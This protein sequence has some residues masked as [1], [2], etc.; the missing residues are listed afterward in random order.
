MREKGFISENTKMFLPPWISKKNGNRFVMH[1]ELLFPT[2]YQIFLNSIYRCY[3]GIGRKYW[4]T[5]PTRISLGQ[6]CAYKDIVM[7]EVL[8]ALGTK[9]LCLSSETSLWRIKT[10]DCFEEYLYSLIC[11]VSRFRPRTEQNRSG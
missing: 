3:S 10:G 7:H 5:G 6:D 4:K 8:H 9:H 1:H 11:V 2:K